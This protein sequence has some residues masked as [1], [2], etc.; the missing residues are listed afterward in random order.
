MRMVLARVMR[1]IWVCAT[2][3]VISSPALWQIKSR[4]TR[5]RQSCGNFTFYCKLPQTGEETDCL[6]E[7]KDNS[8]ISFVDTRNL[9]TFLF[10]WFVSITD[11]PETL[12]LK[13][14][15]SI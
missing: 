11:E 6:Y 15:L 14:M 8:G 5:K 9:F 2:S 1:F 3:C 10:F 4:V 13:I 12:Y 7:D